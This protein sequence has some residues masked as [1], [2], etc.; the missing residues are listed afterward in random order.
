MDELHP[1]LRETAPN[2]AYFQSDALEIEGALLL[3]CHGRREP[4]SKP[5]CDACG[6]PITDGSSAEVDIDLSTKFCHHGCRP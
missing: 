6:Q 5:N 3:T 4:T 2:T 1:K